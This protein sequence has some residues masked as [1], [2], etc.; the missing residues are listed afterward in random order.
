MASNTEFRFLVL[1]LKLLIINYLLLNINKCIIILN[2]RS[3]RNTL[4][5]ISIT[6]NKI[7]FVLACA[8]FIAFPLV[9]VVQFYKYK[10]A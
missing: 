10:T 2:V 9:P 3:V 1:S 4:A 6:I 7:T 8:S 5:L